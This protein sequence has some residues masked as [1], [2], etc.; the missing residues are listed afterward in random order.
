MQLFVIF[1][2]FHRLRLLYRPPLRIHDHCLRFCLSPSPTAIIFWSTMF[3]SCPPRSPSTVI[4]SS[5]MFSSCSPPVPSLSC[6]RPPSQSSFCSRLLSSLPS[7]L[8]SPS[9]PRPWFLIFFFFTSCLR[10]RER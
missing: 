6:P 5:L 7:Y 2:F 8:Q 10:E 3:S 1:V 4:F 9:C